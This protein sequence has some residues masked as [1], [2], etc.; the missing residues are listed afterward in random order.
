MQ[1]KFAYTLYIDDLP[2]AVIY[3]DQQNKDLRPNYFEGIP[4]GIFQNS[5][6][7]DW[8]HAIMIYNHLEMTVFVNPTVE[9]HLRIVGFEVEPFSIGEGK[10]RSL[11]DPKNNDGV[12]YLKAD[13]SFRFTYRITTK[14]SQFKI[15]MCL[16]R[17]TNNVGYAA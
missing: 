3:R 16:G 8:D 12:Q 1:S 10:K 14:V 6:G 13:E 7:W 5:D 17:Q 15:S 4:V 2:S 9:G 11:N